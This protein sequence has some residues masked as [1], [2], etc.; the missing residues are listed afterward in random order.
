MSLLDATT[1]SQRKQQAR[2]QED[3][4]KLYVG[5]ERA[6]TIVVLSDGGRDGNGDNCRQ[7]RGASAGGVE[8]RWIGCARNASR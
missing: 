2:Q 7:R 3:S 5:A 6:G 4:S 1:E 8:S